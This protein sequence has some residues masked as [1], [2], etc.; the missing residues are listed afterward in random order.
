M[1]TLFPGEK[2]HTFLTLDYAWVASVHPMLST[3]NSVVE[4]NMTAGQIVI[5]TSG[6][7]VMEVNLHVTLLVLMDVSMDIHVTLVPLKIHS[8]IYA[9]IQNAILARP[10][11]LVMLIP[12]AIQLPTQVT[13]VNVTT[14]VDTTEMRKKDSVNSS[15]LTDLYKMTYAYVIQD[16]MV[17]KMESVKRSHVLRDVL[18][19]LIWVMTTGESV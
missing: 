1:M 19:V 6:L 16:T 17:E 3:G 2:I 9:Q 15:V 18:S 8:A 5:T 4:N 13:F 14:I 7:M 10:T 12:V 11:P